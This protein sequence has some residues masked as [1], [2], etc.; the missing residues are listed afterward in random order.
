MCVL[1]QKKNQ[2]D[3]VQEKKAFRGKK[4]AVSF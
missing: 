2:D 4:F 3:E 1:K